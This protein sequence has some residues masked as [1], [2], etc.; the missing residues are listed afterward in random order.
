MYLDASENP[1]RFGC[2]HDSQGLAELEVLM[3]KQRSLLDY[4]EHL[5]AILSKGDDPL[6][7]LS[8]TVDFERFRP[9]LETAAGRPR[10]AKG[11]RPA[12]D[13]VLKFKMLVLQSLHNLSLEATETMVRDRMTW[14][15][16][17]GLELN[18]TVP[19]ANTL[20][21][22]RE[23]LIKAGVLDELFKEMN[24]IV[25]EAGFISRSGQIVDSSLV[26]APRQ[27]MTEAE[28][29]AIREGRSAD[30]IWPD[31]PAKASQK[32]TDA[33]WT[34]K[35]KKA[36]ARPDGRKPVDIAIPVFGYKT[37]IGIDKKHGIIRRQIVTDAAANDG[38]RL[39]E[40]LIDHGNTCGDVWGDTGYRSAENERWLKEHGLH[41]RIHRKKPHKRPMPARTAKA[42][43]RKSKDRAKV[44]HVFAHQKARMGLTIRTVG[45]ARAK[46]AVTMANIAY[47]MGRLRWLLGRAKPPPNGLVSA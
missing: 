22:F 21:D 38:K 32:D 46:A 10:G 30:E 25:A 19:D 37:H 7:K 16:F 33:R 26:A 36:K 45:L 24:Q 8:A 29:A 4:D 15:H 41:S 47:N 27:R 1:L 12:L 6:E 31:A 39:R 11:G 20:W 2:R 34:V 13:V 9:I 43:G 40:G 42:N 23:A 14:L 18:E 28:K 5:G 44:E 35:H 3:S 17:C